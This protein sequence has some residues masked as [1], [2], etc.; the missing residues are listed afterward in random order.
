MQIL[1]PVL[2]EFDSDSG[3]SLSIA[4]PEWI[5]RYGRHVIVRGR[6]PGGT[7]QIASFW[8][9]IL[10]TN[11]RGEIKSD[12]DGSF[13]FAIPTLGLP[14]V[15]YLRIVA[16]NE[17][18]QG[19][20]RLFG[21]IRESGAPA[22]RPP[23]S[24]A[25]PSTPEPVRGTVEAA[26]IAREERKPKVRI[27]VLAL[28]QP[29]END[30]FSRELSISG[31]LLDSEGLAF[32]A[33]EIASISW[34]V[35]GSGLKGTLAVD[36]KGS[37]STIVD[38]AA[39]R[40][41][42][43]LIL[44]TVTSEGK[45]DEREVALRADISAPL[46]KL[47]SPL[48]GEIYE[49]LIR[50]QGSAL[51]HEAVLL[52]WQILG[53]SGLSGELSLAKEG[54]FFFDIPARGLKGPQILE[55]RAEDQLGNAT[56]LTV[57]LAARKAQAEIKEPAAPTVRESRPPPQLVIDSPLDRSYYHSQIVVNG[58]AG[59]ADSLSWEIPGSGLEG[60]GIIARDGRFSFQIFSADLRGTQLIRLTATGYAGEKT[61]QVLVLLDDEKGPE[62]TITAP[63]NR[64]YYRREIQ[65][66]GTVGNPQDDWNSVGE[67][68]SLSLEI[69]GMGDKPL[70]IPFDE[71]G[72]FSLIHPATGFSRK[73]TL[74]LAALD[75]N[76]DLS[77]K[78]IVL[79]D[80]NL[81]PSVSITSP[82]LDQLYGSKV[83]VSGAIIDPYAD[84]AVMGGIESVEYNVTSPEVFS[85]VKTVPHDEIELRG[86]NTFDFVITTRE[87]SGPQDINILVR[88]RSGNQNKTSVRILEG[89]ADIPVFSVEA[90]DRR[91]VLRWDP[92]PSTTRYI[93]RYRTDNPGQSPGPKKTVEGIS[94]PYVLT[95]LENGN[96]Y[97]FRVEAVLPGE[98]DSES[99][100]KW[101]IPLSAET[102]RPATVG[103]FEQIRISWPSIP[104]SELYDL[105]RSTGRDGEYTRVAAGLRDTDYLDRDVR[106]GRS[107][108]YRVSAASFPEFPSNPVPGES[109]AFPVEKLELAGVCS[110]NQARGLTLYGGYAFV[111]GGSE[112]VKIVDISEPDNPTQV[113]GFQ[114]SEARD[115]A[116]RGEY[117]FVADGE[118]GLKV[119]DISDPRLPVQIGMRKTMDA[120]AIAL[121]AE[122]V[123]IADGSSGV[124]IIDVSSPVQPTRIG[125]YS[126]QNASD[127]LIHANKLY[128]A[129]GAGGLRIFEVSDSAALNEVAHLD[130]IEVRSVAA[131]GSLLYLAAGDEGL[132]IMDISAP[133]KPTELGRYAAG[134]TLD[135]SVSG[136]FAYILDGREGMIVVDVS[137]PAR[138]RR[139][140]SFSAEQVSTISVRGQYA[141]LATSSGLQVVHILIQGRSVPVAS[142]AMGGKAFALSISGERAYVA[143]HDRGVRIVDV[144]NPTGLTDESLIG[145]WSEGY[146][147]GIETV[148]SVAFV[149]SGRRGLSILDLSPLWDDDPA[150]QPQQIGSYYTGGT[151]YNTVARSDLLFVADGREGLKVLDIAVPNNPVEIGSVACEQARDVV[152]IAGYALIAD[153]DSG[154]VVCDISDPSKPKEVTTM[155][156]QGVQQVVAQDTLVATAG[157]SGVDLYDFADPRNPEVLGRFE[158]EYV[159]SICLSGPYLYTAEGH[160][161][162][163][164][165]DILSFDRPV[166]VSACPD[167]Y[168]VDVEVHRGYALVADSRQL[169]TIEVLIPE[170][171]RRSSS[172][173]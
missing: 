150:T 12:P 99:A 119:L 149:T 36:R 165:L 137:D 167:V 27:P 25:Q 155:G 24:L 151:A 8:W 100:E 89:E 75:R 102:M 22:Y 20:E 38:T 64:G 10:D 74:I 56:V 142:S 158:S 4:T 140:A 1:T 37:F 92:L 44:R 61:E 95:G 41:D 162:L 127:L 47:V 131:E 91:T 110:L 94:S 161:G 49:E 17:Y 138:P 32:S 144:S 70:E 39:V 164:V 35:E 34:E 139:F 62:I 79:L 171:L 123:F 48:D 83:R 115:I 163:T 118:R 120:R 77:R 65:L 101:T 73:Q 114:T 55:L 122:A 170:W 51:D 82:Q 169:R 106:Y 43:R 148:D 53:A 30:Y 86:D 111:A 96:R 154:L 40:Q 63:D 68:A 33:E 67:V 29:R 166:R 105:W 146:A 16:V 9:E 135:V 134:E 50:V 31:T 173:R 117:A 69:A 121:Q 58:R 7:T 5:S 59:N 57:A 2:Q 78:T 130:G 133:E 81:N 143:C 71:K 21:L 136:T 84:S 157:R 13:A 128:V 45:T 6:A 85:L 147:G 88:A 26:E 72:R 126:T 52:Y 98:P 80:G 145:A 124:K 14:T 60:S 66:E 3:L 153:G 132:I 11:H 159:E 109:T 107:Y 152:V 160:R 172:M 90:G 125:S 112:G 168:A 87:L 129:D 103:E 76:G 93:L 141:Y 116:V 113:G 97:V 104:G 23:P 42:T 19:A 156:R 108:Y 54:D 46:L 28:I 18:G 15:F